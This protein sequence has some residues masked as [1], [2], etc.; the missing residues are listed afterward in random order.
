MLEFI[1][2]IL[3]EFVLQVVGETLVELGLYSVA[4]PFRRQ[5]KPWL[6]AVG[7]ALFGAVLGGLSL[8]LF[9]VNF[10]SPARR[11]VNLIVTPIGV[12]LAMVVLGNWRARRGQ[13]VMRID[14]FSYG[15]LFAL[16]LALVRY[17]FS[18]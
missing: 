16:S 6:A 13:L 5:P 2:E 17:F 7:Y 3:A 14:R 15:Y 9:P 11:A 10:V 12:G 1:F 4:E 18:A 8:V